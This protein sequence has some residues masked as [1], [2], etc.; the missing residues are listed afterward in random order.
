MA[1][2]AC[3]L[4]ADACKLLHEYHI[5]DDLQPVMLGTNFNFHFDLRI[6]KRDWLLSDFILFS[7][8]SLNYLQPVELRECRDPPFFGPNRTS[9]F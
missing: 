9:G 8:Y 7:E 6:L 1:V 3:K 2:E 5:A 4:I